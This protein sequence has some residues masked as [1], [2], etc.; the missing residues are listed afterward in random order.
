[1]STATINNLAQHLNW[2]LKEKPFAPPAPPVI[3]ASSGSESDNVP[4]PTSS[5]TQQA[6]SFPAITA[7]SPIRP[8]IERQDSEMARL[9]AGPTT[10]ASKPRMLSNGST[11]ADQ[12]QCSSALV[13]MRE[14]TADV[15]TA[16]RKPETY[17]PT[18]SPTSR[19]RFTPASR[20]AGCSKSNQTMTLAPGMP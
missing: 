9:R 20:C 7:R 11:T 10:S 5:S 12:S 14:I 19:N 3:T 16:R 15:N 6:A 4:A 1:M 17:S 13:H 2:L 18:Y 8:Q